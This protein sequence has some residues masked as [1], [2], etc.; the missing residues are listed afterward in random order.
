MG[1]GKW[2]L[3]ILMTIVLALGFSSLGYGITGHP[4]GAIIGGI[5]GA[6]FTLFTGRCYMADP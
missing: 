3:L 4:A 2:T 6:L 1:K 5:L